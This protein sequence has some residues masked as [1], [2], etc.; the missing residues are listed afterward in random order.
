MQ[1]YIKH[2]ERMLLMR[3]SVKPVSLVI[4]Q[5]YMPTEN[6]S[7]EKI[8]EIYEEMDKVLNKVKEKEY[9]IIMGD[10]NIRIERGTDEGE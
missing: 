3:I 4:V 8:E 6:Y 7:E 10:W 2:S 5:I 1:S 9:L